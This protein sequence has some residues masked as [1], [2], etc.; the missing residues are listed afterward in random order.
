L[1]LVRLPRIERERLLDENV[2]AGVERQQ[3]VRQ[4][5]WMGRRD[6]DRVDLWIG[7]EILIRAVR[8]WDTEPSRERGR[9]G[10]AAGTDRSNLLACLRL[11]GVDESFGDPP[12][13]DHAPAERGCLGRLWNA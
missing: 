3:A 2:L 12:G 9:P 6:V 8:P 5:T 11:N 7:D 1:E 10:A 4:V 13:T